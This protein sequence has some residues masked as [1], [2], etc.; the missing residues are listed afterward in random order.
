M[1]IFAFAPVAAALNAAYSIVTG[2]AGLLFPLAGGASAAVAIIV[3]TVL[4]RAALIPVG[5][6]Q[7]RAQ[8]NR[9]RIAPKLQEIQR[10]YKNN[11]ELL[12]RKTQELYASEKVSPFA[13]MLPTLAQAPVISLVYGLFVRPEIGGQANALLGQHLL[14]VPLGTSLGHLLS[15]GALFP[16]LLVFVAL[17]GVIAIVAALSRRAALAMTPQTPQTPG[18]A[19]AGLAKVLSWL[20]FL[21]VVFAGIVPLAATLYLAVTTTWTLIERAILRRRLDGTPRLAVA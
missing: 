13:G 14:G 11:R 20:P 6:S 21:T 9:Q 4:L 3:V 18:A 2:L 12:M 8:L 10:R 19:G 16:G 17:L 5:R 1:D 15:S 7:M